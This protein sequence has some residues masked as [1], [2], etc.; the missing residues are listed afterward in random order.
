M[1]VREFFEA[2]GLTRR[3]FNI[4][5]AGRL[6]C[7][8]YYALINLLYAVVCAGFKEISYDDLGEIRW[9]LNRVMRAVEEAENDG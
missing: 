9:M 1:S 4:I 2:L 8:E 3:I 5:F 6:G 7:E